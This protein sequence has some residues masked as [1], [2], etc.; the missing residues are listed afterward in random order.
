[1]VAARPDQGRGHDDRGRALVFEPG[2]S[3][4]H[5][6]GDARAKYST[7]CR[8]ELVL[9]EVEP[10]AQKPSELFV[11]TPAEGSGGFLSAGRIRRLT[12]KIQ[13]HR[14]W[15]VLRESD[16]SRTGF[17]QSLPQI[18]PYDTLFILGEKMIEPTIARSKGTTRAAG[19]LF[20]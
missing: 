12:S 8:L 4:R 2:K 14:S 5:K 7:A 19:S 20:D 17:C 15:S 18:D 11:G 1:V 13:M 16:N 10:L 9:L 6:R 3:E